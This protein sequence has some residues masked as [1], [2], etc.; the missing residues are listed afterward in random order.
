MRHIS[1]KSLDITIKG[2][3]HTNDDHNY[4]MEVISNRND[5]ILSIYSKEHILEPFL[6]SNQN[7]DLKRTSIVKS[8]KFFPF[9]YLCINQQNETYHLVVV[10]DKKK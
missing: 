10:H 8:R 9:I 7:Y 1:F 6:S 5:N 2:E 4:D 3:N